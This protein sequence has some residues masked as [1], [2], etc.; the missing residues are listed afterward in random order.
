MGDVSLMFPFHNLVYSI[1]LAVV[2]GNC[3]G[4]IFRLN[5]NNYYY[6]ALKISGDYLLSRHEDANGGNDFLLLSGTS[7]FIH[8]GVQQWNTLTVYANETVMQLWVNDHYLATVS[9][10]TLSAGTIGVAVSVGGEKIMTNARF[11]NAH[12]WQ[13]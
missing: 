8:Q 9:D 11:R 4:L 5:H 10:K 2:Q 6:F 12:V 13:P 3:A 1:D 7:P